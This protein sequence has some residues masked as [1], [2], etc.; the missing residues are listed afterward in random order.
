MESSSTPEI[1]EITY[2]IPSFVKG[3]VYNAVYY[4]DLQI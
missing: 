4:G 2:R 3:L 1:A